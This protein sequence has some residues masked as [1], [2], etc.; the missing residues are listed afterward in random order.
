M[1]KIKCKNELRSRPKIC[2]LIVVCLQT[3]SS[4]SQP[5]NLIE[6]TTPVYKAVLSNDKTY[7][8]YADYEKVEIIDASTMKSVQIW[9]HDLN[10]QGIVSELY[11]HP[12]NHDLLFVRY[13]IYNYEYSSFEGNAYPY[14]SLYRFQIGNNQKIAIPGN[15]FIALGTATDTFIVGMNAAKP[16]G[17]YGKPDLRS[18]GCYYAGPGNIYLYPSSTEFKAN[19]IIRSMCISP[20]NK[21]LAIVYYDSV[22]ATNGSVFSI[23]LRNLVD[24]SVK[25]HRGKIQGEPT[26]LGFSPDG[27]FLHYAIHKYREEK[28]FVLETTSLKDTKDIENV[29]IFPHILN[30]NVIELKENEAV[31]EN[32]NANNK[33]WQIWGNLTNLFLFNGVLALNETEVFIYGTKKTGMNIYEEKGGIEKL[34]LV[35]LS[36]YSNVEKTT[37]TDTLFD[38][39]S[40]AIMNN[41][42][43]VGGD[44]DQDF[45]TP[46]IASELLLHTNGRVLEIWNAA[47]RK[48]LREIY[49][50]D[51]IRAFQGANENQILIL[52]KY[53][54]KQ[55][56]E[57]KVHLL[58]I[59]TGIVQS[60]S[61]TDLK[62]GSFNFNAQCDCKPL[63][64]TQNKW[65]CNN[66]YGDVWILNADSLSIVPKDVLTE[67]E[68]ARLNTT[69]ERTGLKT[70]FYELKSESGVRDKLVRFDCNS[71]LTTNVS[72]ENL[73]ND[74]FIVN[75]SIVG[76]LSKDKLI[77]YNL[78]SPGISESIKMSDRKIIGVTSMGLYS[79]LLFENTK[80][81]YD[82]LLVLR[83]NCHNLSY[84]F[85]KIP[86][87]RNFQAAQN[88]LF[89]IKDNQLF[90]NNNEFNNNES[91]SQK[92]EHALRREMDYDGTKF[93]L[94]EFSYL[95]N[96]STLK[97]SYIIPTYYYAALLKNNMAGNII[98]INMN[99]YST[100][101]NEKPWFELCIAPTDTYL[102]TSWKSNKFELDPKGVLN[103]PSHILI[104][105][106]GKFAVV[107]DE[108]TMISGPDMVLIVN[109]ETREIFKLPE[110]KCEVVYFSDDDSQLILFDAKTET[111]YNTL[112]G[113]KE[114][115]KIVA[116]EMALNGTFQGI[117]VKKTIGEGK[118]EEKN[119]YS[120]ETIHTTFFSPSTGYII[121][122]DDKGNVYFWR[123]EVLSPFAKIKCGSQKITKIIEEKNHLLAFAGN[124]LYIID[125][126]KLSLVVTLNI[127]SGQYN[128]TAEW[129]TPN[130]YFSAA[131][132]KIA[133]LHIV[134]KKNAAPVLSYEIFLN[135]PDIILS[136][137][138]YGEASTINTYK[139]AWKKRMKKN[140][141]DESY[142]VNEID[143]PYI[144]LS[145][146]SQLP[147]STSSSELRLDIRAS[148]P[149]GIRKLNIF[150]NGVP[151]YGS[152][153]L[154]TKACKQLDKTE[155]LQLHEGKNL[156]ELL[157]TD[158]NGV[159][160]DPVTYEVNCLQKSESQIYYIGVG[161]S[162]YRDKKY[163]LEYAVKDEQDTREVIL[164][165]YP[166]AKVYLLLD[167]MTTRENILNL[168]REVLL[169]TN[170][171]DVVMVGFSGHGLIDSELNF[172]Y[173]TWG[174]EFEN[175]SV[176]SLP[177]A[178]MEWLLD[179]IPAR[180]KLLLIDACHSGEIDKEE[181]EEMAI[182]STSIE[183]VKFRDNGKNLKNKNG[184]PVS[185]VMNDLFADMNTRSGTTVISSSGG[186]EYSMESGQWKNG[187]F[188][189]CFLYGL[190]TNKADMNH[191]GQI[192]LSEIKNYVRTEVTRLSG[193]SQQPNTRIENL[194]M[195][196]RIW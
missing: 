46:G 35:D 185:S 156:I 165:K 158:V 64:S 31:S 154:N 10:T 174:S 98:Y 145:N 189:Y 176:R 26:E 40:V 122:G 71:F 67:S 101:A 76:Y 54:V 5:K 187:L 33:N 159:E 168:K 9:K 61:F 28:H 15:A 77:Y 75:D 11:F 104:S 74:Y 14:D 184:N 103:G 112:T 51:F 191:D 111:V 113:K 129:Y 83:V 43:Y 56:G 44:F 135:R 50:D 95:L 194:N 131:R 182:S 20:N 196:F 4:W 27:K 163:A 186:V 90:Y 19:G 180:K 120:R 125:L 21:T 157:V 32:W 13:S 16:M 12:S 137:N 118:P 173:A 94:Y 53:E 151:I 1:E 80:K 146:K 23:E 161:V 55:S 3:V 124:A 128:A 93:I 86:Y 72:L 59:N 171:N 166:G 164:K 160:S 127:T 107:Y 188:T 139:A 18:K 115:K 179:S 84:N 2:L 123:Q 24:M 178:D 58:D 100:Y 65:V 68:K 152:D 52:E 73:P 69:F 106:N 89:F 149:K 105:H 142:K 79:Y 92:E 17:C 87:T 41:R 60:K 153:G 70:I 144:N 119:Y 81:T 97:F 82:S 132:D 37:K 38:P 181:V 170:V 7:L 91:W 34:N 141:Y 102:E 140:G 117:T 130:G 66:N 29:N 126:K 172:Y 88:G 63:N 150:V 99:R 136:L 155:L 110:F 78:F 148:S 45:L 47:E 108:P 175:P 57:F 116:R 85:L 39:G 195:D 30:G 121:G 8:A 114:K 183:G 177:Y 193:G 192:M 169:K 134:N 48:K 147:S 22:W 25:S 42:L 62:Y 162:A 190:E 138:G 6:T 143:R 133:Q 49:F 109:L 36:A 167:S 96:L